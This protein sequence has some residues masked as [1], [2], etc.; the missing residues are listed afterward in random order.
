MPTKAELEAESCWRAQF[1]PD[2][3]KVFVG[4]LE[5]YYDPHQVN[6]G[7]YG[8][9][10]HLKGYHRSRRWIKQSRF[11]ASRSYSVT[12]TDGNRTGG[13]DDAI[14]GVDLIVGQQRS[15]QIFERVNYAKQHGRLPYLR[16]VLLERDPWHV[17]FSIDRGYSNGDFTRLFLIITGQDDPQEGRVSFHIDMP[18]LRQGDE[19]GN[20]VT[21]QAL[22]HARGFP[23]EIDGEFGP[24]TDTQTRRMQQQYDAE[25]VDGIWGPETWTIAITGEDRL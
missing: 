8:D 9:Y 20:V 6:V 13:D 18:A 24:D 10:R 11:A 14:S 19:G 5:A 3:L 1:V 16:Q 21:A 22:L 2:N 12:E 17:H 25:S 15:T 23:T 7:A 4:R